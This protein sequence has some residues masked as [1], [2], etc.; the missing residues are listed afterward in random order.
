MTPPQA[1][2][3][4]PAR[5]LEST[6]TH[7]DSFLVSAALCSFTLLV[8]LAGSDR[9]LH[10]FV[11]PVLACGILVGMDAYDWARG[12]MSLFDP[13]GIIGLLGLHFFFLAPLLHISWNLLWDVPVPPVDWRVDLG[14]MAVLNLIGLLIYRGTRDIF[15]RRAPQTSPVQWRLNKPVFFFIMPLMLLFTGLLQLWVYASYGGIMGYIAAATAYEY[16]ERMAGMGIVFLFSETFP[17]LAMML[18]A[19]YAN[20][21]PRWQSWPVMI[22]VMVA[23]LVLK[24][25]FGGLRGSRAEILFALLW[26]G[27]ILHFYV[28]PF[29][30]Q[31]VLAGIAFMVAFMY[32]Y[33]FYKAVG[34][35]A[36]QAI[37]DPAARAEIT[38]SSGRDFKSV[39][40]GDLSRSDVQAFIF[41]R[42]WMPHSVTKSDY[43]YGWG[44]TYYGALALFVPGAIWSNRPLAK[45]KEG[46][47]IVYGMGTYEPGETWSSKIYGLAGEAMLNFGILA[48]PFAFAIWGLVVSLTRRLLMTLKVG[49]ARLLMFPYLV[50][51]CA[52]L[53]TADSDNLMVYLVQ[54]G[55]L[56]FLMVCASSIFI[57]QRAAAAAPATRAKAA[58]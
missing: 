23:F 10:W 57:S 16:P 50:T 52:L 19:A 31:A 17:I 35:D 54:E 21:K 12:R 36:F 5:W 38:E 39:L 13:V 33:G 55:A 58:I 9:L 42:L 47:E 2:I 27:G 15:V 32:V 14:G 22:G 7:S 53:L 46:T 41:D 18:F 28:R 26:G 3:R 56:P 29:P 45:V 6:R 51:F 44:R 30:R 43:Q 25:L 11:L 48:V 4:T 49:D 37:D 1:V 34:A 20:D 40:L 24:I 8:L